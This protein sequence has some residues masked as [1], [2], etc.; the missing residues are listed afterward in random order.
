ARSALLGGSLEVQRERRS[1]CPEGDGH[2]VPIA[3][4]REF[5]GEKSV[6][7]GGVR[8]RGFLFNPEPS[9]FLRQPCQ[10]Q[11]VGLDVFPVGDKAAGYGA[12]VAAEEPLELLPRKPLLPLGGFQAA[13]LLG[14]LVD[15]R[16]AAAGLHHAA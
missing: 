2:G 13:P 5:V 9:L 4:S 1:G 3:V 16:D 12:A 10:E 6:G 11:A 14:V 7:L 15:N 8:D